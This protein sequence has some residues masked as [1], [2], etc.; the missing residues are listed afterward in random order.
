MNFGLQRLFTPTVEGFELTNR[1]ADDCIVGEPTIAS[2][3]PEFRWPGGVQPAGVQP[4]AGTRT[5]YTPII[6]NMK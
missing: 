6:M 4:S 3:G 1:T 5:E 2:G